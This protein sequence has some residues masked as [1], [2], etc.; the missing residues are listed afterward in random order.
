MIY[1]HRYFILNDDSREVVDE[2]GR[3]TAITGNTYLLLF[4]LCKEGTFTTVTDLN[5]FIDR[6]ADINEENIR[7]YRYKIKLAL[8]HDV[9]IY[10]NQRY[11]IDGEVKKLEKIESKTE[12]K[13]N[14]AS[15]IPQKQATENH[16]TV[17]IRSLGY[18][19]TMKLKNT[20]ILLF[21]IILLAVFGIYYYSNSGSQKCDIKGNISGDKIYHLP[22]C[23]SYT[24][25][26]IDE[27]KGE[28]WFCSEKEAIEA[29]WRKAKN[30]D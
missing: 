20:K 18:N 14:L 29:G 5:D 30:C 10:K 26:T 9:I 24:K 21:L 16:I 12:I 4:F 3:Q 13:E 22:N 27:S 8:G 15:D 1:K 28:R 25:T 2:F 7:Q 6:E 11:S 23:L 19:L 17:L